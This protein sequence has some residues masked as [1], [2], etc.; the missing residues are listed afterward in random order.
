MKRILSPIFV[1]TAGY[2]VGKCIANLLNGLPSDKTI[3]LNA[4]GI[5]VFTS[6]FWL[7]IYFTFRKNRYWEDELDKFF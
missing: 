5:M 2:G 6:V 1:V 7:T 4:M 3:F